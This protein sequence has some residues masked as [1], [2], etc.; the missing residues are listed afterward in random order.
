MRLVQRSCGSRARRDPWH[1]HRR[2]QSGMAVMR[3]DAMALSGRDPGATP[4]NAESYIRGGA[5]VAFQGQWLVGHETWSHVG[6][7][8]TIGRLSF[9]C[10]KLHTIWHRR[11]A[12][13]PIAWWRIS[14][15]R[16]AQT[17]M[18]TRCT[19]KAGSTRC[20]KATVERLSSTPDPAP[21]K[22]I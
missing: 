1:K 15:D 4:A 16:V 7:V 14:L 3:D 2:V 11:R 10:R 17:S 8:R 21:V 6:S 19:V 22:W 13:R 12:L 18:R 20:D 5:V 9:Q